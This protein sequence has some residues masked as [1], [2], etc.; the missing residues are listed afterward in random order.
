MLRIVP[1]LNINSHSLTD[2]LRQTGVA[3]PEGLGEVKRW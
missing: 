1:F 3:N 2:C